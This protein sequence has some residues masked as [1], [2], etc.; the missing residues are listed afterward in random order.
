LEVEREANKPLSVKKKMLQ[1][2]RRNLGLGEILWK[3]LSNGEWKRDYE[4]KN[5]AQDRDKWQFLE[6][7]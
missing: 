2:L 3:D 5:E 7:C 6:I 1:H 4:L